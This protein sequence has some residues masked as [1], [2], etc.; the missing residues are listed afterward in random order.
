MKVIT[1]S[2]AAEAIQWDAYVRSSVVAK[3]CHQYGWRSVFVKSYRHPCHYLA[4]IAPTGKWRGILPLVHVNSKIF[5][6]NLVS[7]P[8]VNHGG[9]L[10]DED[11]AGTMLLEAAE[12]L[13][14]SCGAASVELRHVSRTSDE[15]PTKKH[16]VTMVLEMASDIDSQW[17]AFDSKLRNQIRKAEKSDL[18][19]AE[20]RLE[21]LDGFYEVLARNMRDLGSPV[22]SKAFFRNVLEEFPGSTKILAVYLNRKMIAAGIV[23]WFGDVIEIPWAS[24]NRDY[25]SFCP[26]NLLYWSA[27]R[28]AMGRGLKRF[29]FGRSTPNEGT[30]NF[31]KQWGALPVQLNW[32]YLVGERDGVLKMDSS[33]RKYATAIAVWQRLPVLLTKIIGPSIRRSISL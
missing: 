19:A 17:R 10:C 31:K 24:S 27:I 4:A 33:D 14:G 29:D 3:G 25:N 22:H 5:G 1:V 23:S 2:S 21:L 32:Q 12:K 16:K 13:R 28:F 6:N 9:L 30:Y 20:G 18:R 26:N 11:L 15:L 8:F 7:L